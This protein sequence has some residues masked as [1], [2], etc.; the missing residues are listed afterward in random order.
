MYAPEGGHSKET[1]TFRVAGGISGCIA[2]T[3]S[4]QLRVGFCLR[5]TA[6]PRASSPASAS[7]ATALGT[8]WPHMRGL[9]MVGSPILAV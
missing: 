4:Q 3:S 9:P 1:L 2:P 7:L 5:V 8:L 6:Q